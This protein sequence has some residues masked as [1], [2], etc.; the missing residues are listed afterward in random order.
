ML[1]LIVPLASSVASLRQ[2]WCKGQ[3]IW[4]TETHLETIEFDLHQEQ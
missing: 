2:C 4:V 3:T 1:K